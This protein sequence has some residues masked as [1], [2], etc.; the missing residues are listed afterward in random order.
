MNKV[1]RVLI[2]VIAIALAAFLAFGGTNR[3]NDIPEIEESELMTPEYTPPVT[4]DDE[5]IHTIVID[6]P[7]DNFW[8]SDTHWLAMAL[9]LE[10]GPN[11]DPWQIVMIGDVVMHRVWS[12]E[13]PDTVKDVL[14][15]PGQYEPFFGDFEPFMPEKKYIDIAEAIIEDGES[16]L[17]DPRI[18][19]QALFEQGA[20][21]VFSIYDED[22][23]TTTYFCRD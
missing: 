3:D 22:L 14:L 5:L 15:D 17:S 23:G 21:T 16:Y 4:P 12:D 19:Y 7:E 20:K 2:A 13:Y 8:D 11:W 9:Q 18:V 10:S 1:V 6:E